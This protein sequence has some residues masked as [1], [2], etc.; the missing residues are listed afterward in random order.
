MLHYLP[1]EAKS[2]GEF[3]GGVEDIKA[4]NIEIKG[5]PEV[6]AVDQ[7]SGTLTYLTRLALDRGIL[8]SS[9]CGMALASSESMLHSAL[10]G[11]DFR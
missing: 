6:L 11:L 2:T 9:V 8:L 3:E 1:K 4:T 10:S 5:K 7:S